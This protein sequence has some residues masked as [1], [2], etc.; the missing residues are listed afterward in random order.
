M[1]RSKLKLLFWIY[2]EAVNKLRRVGCGIRG[3][4]FH[5]LSCCVAAVIAGSLCT[6]LAYAFHDGGVGQCGGCHIMHNVLGNNAGWLLPG[7][8][9]S[10]VCLTCHTG[11]GSS[12]SYHIASP[13]G[14]A[15]TPGGDFYW[16]NK[17]FTW[18]TGSSSGRSHGHNIVAQDYGFVSDS[19]LLVAPGGAYRASDLGCTSCHDPHGKSISGLPV[20]GSGSYGAVP[21]SGTELGAYRLLGGNGYDGGEHVQGYSFNYDAPVARQNPAIPFGETD[22]SHV[23]YGSGMSEWCANCHEAILA[24]EH[25]SGGSGFE[26][27]I[28]SSA[29]LE[30]AV[31]RY[32]SYIKT[33]DL[34]G[35]STTA[36]L[37]FVPFERGITDASLLNPTSTVG[38]DSSSHIMCLTCHRAHASAFQHAGRW[39]FSAE[40]VADSHPALGDGGVTGNDIFYSYY[41][42]DMV[43]EFGAAQRN[44]CEKCHDVPRDG[45]PPGW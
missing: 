6:S 1:S 5:G 4:V 16:M 32:N 18:A 23:D 22:L 24:S 3:V 29:Y 26:H 42:R 39:D 38:P 25:K 36:Y 28:G 7:T 10:S 17:D 45:Y 14:S 13:D 11:T 44:L 35:D 9:P 21:A 8:D 37:S 19:L 34:S 30:D 40:L 20:S 41:D 43:I 31:L 2:R 33:G 15:M 12:S 27:P